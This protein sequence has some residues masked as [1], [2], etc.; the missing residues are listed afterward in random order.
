MLNLNKAK[1]PAAK[2]PQQLLRYH[3][4][5]TMCGP[6]GRR[7]LGVIHASDVTDQHREFC[8]RERLVALLVG[9]APKSEWVSTSQ[10]LTYRIGRDVQ[11]AVVSELG[12]SG[13]GFA[14]WYCRSCGQ[15]WR[16]APMPKGCRCGNPIITYEERRFASLKTKISGGIDAFARLGQ[17]LLTPVEVKTVMP[18]QFKALKMPLAEH[19]VRTKL[20]LKL[21]AESG[22]DDVQRID[23]QEAKVLYVSKGGY[24]AA[25]P[26]VKEWKLG[27]DG[28]SPFKEFT[29]Q[30][31][32]KVVAPYEAKVL[33]YLKHRQDRTI[34]KP[35][36][37]GPNVPRAMKC[38][39]RDRCF[40]GAYPTG[41]KY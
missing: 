22:D 38:G 7:P 37:A 5:R 36:C 35:I 30:R 17:A 32:D 26:M 18:D 28:Y 9:A 13:V 16:L 33:E 11:D 14:D 41:A 19:E 23:V 8:G 2:D 3:L 4:H 34:P 15:K 24:G 40:S 25:E 39:V 6:E 10:S 29:V 12:R 21:I 31:D 20:Y 1:P 27:D